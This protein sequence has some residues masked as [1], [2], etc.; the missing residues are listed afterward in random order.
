MALEKYISI[1]G[2]SSDGEQDYQRIQTG[3]LDK[4]AGAGYTPEGLLKVAE[5]LESR[6]DGVYIL[7]NALG[8]HEYYS[9]NRNGDT[10]PEWSLKGEA[11]PQQLIEK[12]AREGMTLADVGQR[13]QGRYGLGTFMTDAHVFRNHV[14]GDPAGSIGKV[15]AADYNDKMHRVELILFIRT[16]DAPDV[17]EDVNCGSPVAFSMGARLLKDVCSICG[18]AVNRRADYCEHLSSQLKQVMPDGRA[19]FSW[20]Y[21][22]LFF[23]IS[24]VQKPADRAAYMLRKVASVDCEPESDKHTSAKSKTATPVKRAKGIPANVARNAAAVKQFNQGRPMIKVAGLTESSA[25]TLHTLTAAGILLKQAECDVLFPSADLPATFDASKVDQATLKKLA[26][27]LTKTSLFIPRDYPDTTNEMSQ[28][29]SS[30]AFTK[31]A[32]Y[33]GTMDDVSLERCLSLSAITRMDGDLSEVLTKVASSSR[34][35]TP[36]WLPFVFGILS[37]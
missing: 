8:A 14:N 32:A 24:K 25:T 17:V 21:F 10:F 28:V 15:I 20:N 34:S 3:G 37:L 7:I 36:A 13:P 33:L 16:A 6:D 30:A 9:H 26:S 11:P 12:L 5:G 22:P 4:L 23:D 19:V 1:G 27:V 35:S 29:L 31:Y 18:K 2:C